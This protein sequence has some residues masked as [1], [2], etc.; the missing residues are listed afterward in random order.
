LNGVISQGCRAMRTALAAL[1]CICCVAVTCVKGYT[2]DYMLLSEHLLIGS[3]YENK[4][5]KLCK[6]PLLYV[7]LLRL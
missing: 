7:Q 5:I 6:R 3:D 2:A 4:V 1:K